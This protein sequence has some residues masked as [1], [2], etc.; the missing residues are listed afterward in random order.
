M[1]FLLLT[2]NDNDGIGQH[3]ARLNDEFISLGH[4]SKTLVLHKTTKNK[5]IIK[6][7]RSILKRIFYFPLNF[8]KKQSDK[9]FSFGFAGI[10]FN[11]IKSYIH[12]ADI[13]IIYSFF[14]ALSIDD[15]EKL[16]NT[17]KIIYFRALDMELASGGCH[18]NFDYLGNE[19]KKYE[20]NCS[21]CPQ[22]NFLNIFNLSKKIIFK[23]KKILE[24][25]KPRVL[26][27]NTF[28]KNLYQKSFSCKNLNIQSI[29]LGINEKRSMFIKKHEARNKLKFNLT[30]KII[31]FGTFN[32][33]AKHKGGE[34]IQNF[35]EILS[36]KLNITEK[37]KLVTFGR[38]QTFNINVKNI[39]WLHLGVIRDDNKLNLLYRAADLMLS[40]S[41]GCNGPHIVNEAISNNLPVIAFEQGVA[42]DAILN[43]INGFKIKCFDEELF[44]KK[45]YDSLFNIKFDF[46]NE[47]NKKI[48]KLFTSNSEAKEIIKISNNDLINL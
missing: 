37:V 9:L 45:I 2:N 25:Y 22:L 17:K 11:V 39:Q 47:K 3:A 12:K 43:N 4:Q 6:I 44:A 5:N 18:V 14:N 48:K 40:P 42:I 19:C 21:T 34:K 8:L 10:G 32:L 27:E 13:I 38:K 1:K 31:L 20:A 24:K 23:K 33:D 41:T 7:E 46:N 36:K 29:F 15:I 30:D 16:L 28:T 26:V 35:L